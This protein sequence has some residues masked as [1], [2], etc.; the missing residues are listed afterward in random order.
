METNNKNTEL[1]FIIDKSGSMSGLES[2]TIG[3]FNSMLNQH[4][5]GEGKC[6]LSTIFFSDHQKT[7]HDRVDIAT[8]KPLTD[9]DYIPGGCTALLDTV[10]NSINHTKSILSGAD[11]E[12]VRNSKVVYVIITD[13]YENAS[14]EYSAPQIKDMITKQQEAG[15]EFVFLGANID[16]V[17]TAAT[18]GIKHNKA[19]NFHAD[20]EG[21]RMSFKA[22]TRLVGSVRSK[23]CACESD[24]DEL[25]ADYES[26]K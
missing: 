26:R 17:S 5:K 20:E 15:W 25:R 16:A 1:V 4:K 18:Y 23:G 21:M 9:A 7:I 2:D 19:V 3:G 24:L 6:T 11:D 8:V 10:G 22:L 13:G 14:R 12:A